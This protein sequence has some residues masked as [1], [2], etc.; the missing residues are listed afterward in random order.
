MMFGEGAFGVVDL[1]QQNG[2][3]VAQSGDNGGVIVRLHVAAD[4]HAI[5]SDDVLGETIVFNRDRHA[6]QRA[7]DVAFSDLPLGGLGLLQ[8]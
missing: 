5:G 8:R 4:R 2:A 7:F 3:G 1:A 6:V